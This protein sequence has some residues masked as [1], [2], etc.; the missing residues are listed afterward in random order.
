MVAALAACAG[1][2]SL[3]QRRDYAGATLAP[4]QQATVF[5]VWDTGDGGLTYLCEIDGRSY[6]RTGYPNPCP[7]VLYVLPGEHRVGVET[8]RAG[9]VAVVI[10]GLRTEAARTYEISV[11]SRPGHAAFYVR[12]MEPGF[13]LTYRDVAPAYFRK[14]NRVNAPVD[15]A[16]AD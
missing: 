10:V 3:V 1:P 13:T 4:H 9:R 7:S 2:E 8:H 5:A 15:P 14:G 12:E 11:D 6:R 16:N